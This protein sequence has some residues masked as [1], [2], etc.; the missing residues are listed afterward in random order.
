MFGCLWEACSF[1]TGDGGGGVVLGRGEVRE[2]GRSGERGTV[3]V[4][5]SGV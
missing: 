2:A 5:E 3:V 1:L 4:C